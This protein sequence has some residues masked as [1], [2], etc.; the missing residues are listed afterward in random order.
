MDQEFLLDTNAFYNLLKALNPA[1]K[2]DG[3]LPTSVAQLKNQK[4][5]VSS[6]TEVEI[7]SVLGKYARGSQGGVSKCNCIISPEGHI[8][9]NNRY[10]EPRKKW[11]NK[12]IKAWIQLIDEIFGGTSQLLSVSIES[13]DTSTIIEAKN[14]IK[15]ALVHNFA[16]M[17]AM[18]AATAKLARDGNRDLTVVTSD[19]G[20]KACLSKIGVPCNDFFAAI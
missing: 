4:L 13:F 2:E 11:N 8:C 6:I 1:T 5:I 9:Q 3:A 20:L 10:T 17:D 18:I 16:S 14:V 12:R 7:I 19:K 15:Y